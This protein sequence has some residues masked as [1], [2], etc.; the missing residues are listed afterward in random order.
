MRGYLLKHSCPT[1]PSSPPPVL[2][3]IEKAKIG[4]YFV[5]SMAHG[6]QES[7]IAI[8]LNGPFRVNVSTFASGVLRQTSN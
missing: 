5:A 7:S 8:M 1:T 2:G 3:R 4:L 6:A